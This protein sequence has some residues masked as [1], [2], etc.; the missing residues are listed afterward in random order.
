MKILNLTNELKSEI[1][2]RHAAISNAIAVIVKANAPLAKLEKQRDE[3]TAEIERLEKV[4]LS[5]ANA[6]RSL[7]E[8]R[9]AL[10]LAD[11]RIAELPSTD[12]EKEHQ[13]FALL[14]RAAMENRKVL[15]PT[16]EAYVEEIAE[17]IGAY[18]FDK[19]HAIF[20]ARQ[21]NAAASLATRVTRLPGRGQVIV[22]AKKMLQE[23]EEIL[24]GELN[25]SFTPKA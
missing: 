14:Q 20:V 24:S 1:K 17:K 23:L 6:I 5:D 3:L 8:K 10:E 12:T 13:L 21:T 25:W 19:N 16:H 4:D 2:E 22:A 9:T 15:M 18:S 7:G 11:R